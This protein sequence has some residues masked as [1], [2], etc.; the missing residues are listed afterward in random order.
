LISNNY[1]KVHYVAQCYLFMVIN[2]NVPEFVLYYPK[3]IIL[4]R[5]IYLWGDLLMICFLTVPTV[6]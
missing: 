2:G 1:D 5:Q 6:Q 3:T 4:Q